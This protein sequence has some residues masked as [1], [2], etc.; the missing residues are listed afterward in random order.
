MS[1]A[2]EAKLEEYSSQDSEHNQILEP[3]T[4]QQVL[5]MRTRLEYPLGTME[6]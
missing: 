5:K 1:E 4:P 6:R 3:I 2:L